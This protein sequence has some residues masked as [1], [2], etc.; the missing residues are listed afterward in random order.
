M[1]PTAILFTP[2]DVSSSYSDILPYIQ[3]IVT[4]FIVLVCVLYACLLLSYVMRGVAILKL[5]KKH[6][7]SNGWMGFIPI[8]CDYQLGTVAGEVPIGKK[9]VRRTG[10]W[11]VLWPIISVVAFLAIY[12]PVIF[13]MAFKLFVLGSS[14]D[15]AQY[16]SAVSGSL[17][18]IF[19]AIMVMYLFTIIYSIFYYMVLHKIFSYYH[20]DSRPTFY[21]LLCMFVPLAEPILLLTHSFKTPLNVA[22]APVAVIES[23]APVQQVEVAETEVIEPTE[24]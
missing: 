2:A 11:M 15:P 21:A 16:F 1:N 9:T 7:L 3:P 10:L 6:N 23:Y 18:G 20:N 12:I 14:P 17:A 5:S 4:L 13:D 19:A 8:L 24:G 22:A